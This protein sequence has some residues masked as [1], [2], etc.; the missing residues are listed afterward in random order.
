M[1]LEVVKY[2]VVM[3]PTPEKIYCSVQLFSHWALSLYDILL[4][5][6]LWIIYLY[7]YLYLYLDRY[8]YR[9]RYI[10]YNISIS[11]MS[12][13][14]SAQWLNNWTEQYIFSG[15]G[16]ITTIYFTTSSFTCVYENHLIYSW[17]LYIIHIYIYI[18]IYS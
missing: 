5:D 16:I 13:N 9:Y 15:V 2:I 8:R 14:E 3:I 1:K 10:I 12:Y 11:N 6:I 4:I 18:Y 7:L 17:K